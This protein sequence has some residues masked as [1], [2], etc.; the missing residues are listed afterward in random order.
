[1]K[2]DFDP[3]VVLKIPRNASDELIKRAFRIRAK[4]THP[5]LNGGTKEAGERFAKVEEAYNILSDPKKKL[6]YDAANMHFDK[7]GM[8]WDSKAKGSA[9]EGNSY[10]WTRNNTWGDSN[11]RNYANNG[12][13]KPSSSSS[14]TGNSYNK[15]AST[16]YYA[17][18]SIKAQRI[19]ILEEEIEN[20]KAKRT[21]IKYNCI[22]LSFFVVFLGSHLISL[23]RALWIPA[24]ALI[25][26]ILLDGILS[27]SR[28]K[29]EIAE[30]EEKLRNLYMNG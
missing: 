15:Y 27:N 13:K 4:E 12:N 30:A 28:L 1:M 29:K 14:S 26:F 2:V 11:N 5:D 23:A 21:K 17:G 7:S 24:L 3:Y 6:E 18:K 8:D 9:K 10:N 22:I 25:F 19:Q 16:D 20:K